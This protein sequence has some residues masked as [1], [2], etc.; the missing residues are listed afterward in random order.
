MRQ[1]ASWGSHFERRW[2]VGMGV[3]LSRCLLGGS[4][5]LD[6]GRVFLGFFEGLFGRSFMEEKDW[7]SRFR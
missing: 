5:I 2:V 1:E 7:W 6:V 3:R 4:H